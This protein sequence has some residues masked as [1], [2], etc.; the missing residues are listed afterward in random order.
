MKKTVAASLVAIYAI[1]PFAAHASNLEHALNRAITVRSEATP[2]PGNW[3][4]AR[5]DDQ[6]WCDDRDDCD[7]R[8][9]GMG[10]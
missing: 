9:G 8:I 10:G 5:D 4:L 6:Y 1:G 7:W 3:R 2:V